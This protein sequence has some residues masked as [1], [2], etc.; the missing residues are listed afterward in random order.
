MLIWASPRVGPRD[1]ACLGLARDRIRRRLRRVS[2]PLR[3]TVTTAAS[4]ALVALIAAGFVIACGG[5]DGGSGIEETDGGAGGD[6]AG[7]TDGG[8][9]PDEP[10]DGGVFTTHADAGCPLKYAGPRSGKV[11]QSVARTGASGVVWLTPIYAREIDN[12]FARATIGDDEQTELLRI[13]DFGFQIPPTATIKGVVVQL[14]R[15]ASEN[16]VVDGN[17]ELW[18][19][20][21]PSDRPKVFGPGW[22]RVIVGTHH[23]GQE[24][25]TWGND[26]TPALVGKPGFGT[27][28]WAK[29]RQDDGGPGPKPAAVESMRITIW[30]CE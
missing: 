26:L 9:S 18:L 12:Q 5:T 16:G 6:A 1:L 19:D 4:V 25:D 8:E 21:T 23:Y 15:Q 17:I 14:K 29:R 20:G 22:P 10:D 30:Y 28:I 7:R 3:L 27:E 2:F 13:T 24:I 11:A